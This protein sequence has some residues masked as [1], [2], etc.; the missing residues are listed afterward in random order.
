MKFVKVEWR[1]DPRGYYLDAIAYRRE[2]EGMQA[3]L[4]AGAWAFASDPD[5]Y[6]FAS[7]RCVKDLKIER[8]EIHEG[9][10]GEL[11]LEIRLSPN[12]FK[13]DTGLI[14]RYQSVSGFTVD[15]PLLG[16][17]KVWPNSRRLGDFQLDEVLP[18]DQGC[19]HEIK[20]TGGSVSI[21]CRDLIASWE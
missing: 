6:D 9:G 3:Q 4:P 13:H 2:L 18:H 12:E 5:H 19:S 21:V 15:S 1:D 11:A 17:V 16:N 7:S 10:H 8:M 20:L 14:I